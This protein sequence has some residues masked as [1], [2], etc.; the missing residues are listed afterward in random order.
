MVCS[1]CM[2]T[3]GITES[4]LVEGCF[5]G[6]AGQVVQSMLECESFLSY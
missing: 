6:G 2:R 5:V 4:D 3:R 1:P